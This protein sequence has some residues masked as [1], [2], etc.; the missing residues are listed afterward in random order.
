MIKAF[1]GQVGV[2][3]YV[4]YYSGHGEEEKRIQATG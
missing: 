2:R 4:L 3:N 1:F